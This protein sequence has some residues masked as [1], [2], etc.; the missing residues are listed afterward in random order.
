MQLGSDRRRAARRGPRQFRIHHQAP[1]RCLEN[2]MWRT[3]ANQSRVLAKNW[4][5]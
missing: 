2:S 4:F 3:N 5:E 1:S